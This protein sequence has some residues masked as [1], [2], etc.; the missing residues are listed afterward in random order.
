MGG[1]VL[2]AGLHR[3]PV[4]ALIRTGVAVDLPWQRAVGLET[5]IN[6]RRYGPLAFVSLG[7]DGF[8]VAD[9]YRHRLLE[10][11]GGQ[12]RGAIPLPDSVVESLAVGPHGRIYAGDN[13]KVRVF[14]L[15]GAR[16]E[17]A[18]GLPHRTGA[19]WSLAPAPGGGIYASV[20][21]VG[22]GELTGELARYSAGG[23]REA[24]LAA[25]TVGPQG[26]ARAPIPGALD[27]FVSEVAAGPG[28][29]LYALLEGG[30][31]RTRTVAV[32]NG[33]QGR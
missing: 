15:N 3:V 6:G 16:Q 17:W 19:V 12:L 14:T 21:Q 25:R 13:L 1:L 20:I 33:G 28:D 26:Q 32:W 4:W 24:V 22:Q 2:A 31:R 18:L 10:L 27:A 11:R 23:Q 5:G 9:T 7:G 30:A 8:L 29:R